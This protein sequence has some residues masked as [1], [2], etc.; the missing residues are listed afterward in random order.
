MSEKSELREVGTITHVAGAEGVSI[1][2]E[3][4]ALAGFT[5]AIIDAMGKIREELFAGGFDDREIERAI[6][7]HHD[8]VVDQDWELTVLQGEEDGEGDVTCAFERTDD[9]GLPGC[10]LLA[11][12]AIANR[13]AE[14]T[15][16]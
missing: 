7:A 9:G 5:I 14:V 3:E 12:T 13:K 16:R 4:K 11:V 10:L 1:D 2:A 6:L 8:E 15:K